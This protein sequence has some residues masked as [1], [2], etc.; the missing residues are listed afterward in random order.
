[1]TYLT[2]VI[3]KFRMIV[4]DFKLKQNDTHVIVFIRV[5]YI[6]VGA[7]EFYIETDTFK[8]YLKPYLLSLAF[9]NQLREV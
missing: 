2:L 1:L 9:E 6:K 7:C 4:P 3:Y 8:F 5:P